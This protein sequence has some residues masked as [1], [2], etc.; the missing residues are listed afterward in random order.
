MKKLKCGSRF[1][2]ST[3]ET[4]S[5]NLG[6]VQASSLFIGLLL[7][8]LITAGKDKEFMQN[9]CSCCFRLLANIS[10][11]LGWKSERSSL[12]HHDVDIVKEDKLPIEH[13]QK[14][15]YQLFPF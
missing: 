2:I 8:V 3:A 6:L 1:F 7:G 13:A 15:I 11:L 5:I 9:S 12:R 10:K 14:V 4:Y